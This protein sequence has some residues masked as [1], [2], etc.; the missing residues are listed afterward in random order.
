MPAVGRADFS[1]VN[2][3]RRPGD[4]AWIG[5]WG[6]YSEVEP[7]LWMGGC[8]VGKVP[9]F[10]E[11]I[12]D[13]YARQPYDRGS[14]PYRSAPLL[15]FAGPPEPEIVESLV[16]WVHEQRTA[17]RTVLIHCEAG[18]N[19]SGLVTALYLIR[20][21]GYRPDD[22]IEL[23]REKRGPNALWNGAFVRYLREAGQSRLS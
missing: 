9:T 6:R 13:V 19:R 21:R 23:V 12:V 1:S 18:Q 3:R 8:P 14:I 4:E 10:A 22:A 17:G 11:A 7:G 16:A 20:F 2:V 15:D 5:P